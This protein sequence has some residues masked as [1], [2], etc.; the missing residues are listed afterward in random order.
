MGCKLCHY[1]NINHCN[2]SSGLQPLS[3]YQNIARKSLQKTAA[4]VIISIHS[5]A[6]PPADCSLCHYINIY[7]YISR[8]SLQKIAA[9]VIVS[10]ASWSSSKFHVIH[11]GRRLCL[12]G[13]EQTTKGVRSKWHG[14]LRSSGP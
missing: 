6:I 13:F 4:Y 8:Q 7:I 5:M 1:I 11:F 10:F 12:S 9:Y 14:Y 2:P 3:L